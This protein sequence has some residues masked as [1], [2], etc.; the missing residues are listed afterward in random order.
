MKPRR[1]HRA[2][3]FSIRAEPVGFSIA[4]LLPGEGGEFKRGMSAMSPTE[5]TYYAVV[6]SYSLC[7]WFMAPVYPL[8]LAS[9]GLD[10]LEVNLVLVTYLF[11]SPVFEVPT[12]AVADLFGRKRCFILS[13][14]VRGAAFGLY[15]FAQGLTECLVA[16]FIDAVGTTLAS[17]AL[18]AWAVDGML[19]EGAGQPTSRLFARAQVAGRSMMTVAG[20][21]CGYVAD[22]DI[23]MPWV[24]G[25]A[26]SIFTAVLAAVLMQ[27]SPHAVH[28]TK[29]DRPTLRATSLA[30]AR[31]VMASRPLRSLYALSFALACAGFTIGMTWP[32][33][34]KELA[35]TGHWVLG[36]A[37]A[38][39]NLAAVVG[40]LLVQRLPSRLSRGW[41]LSTIA[42]ARGSALFAAALAPG[43]GRALCAL[44]VNETGFALGEPLYSAWINEHVDSGLRATVL[45]VRGMVVMLGGAVGLTVTGWVARDH[46]IPTAWL[47]CA[48]IYWAVAIAPARS[49]RR[50]GGR[51]VAEV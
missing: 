46:G 39:L 1:R 26:G 11:T 32:P 41:F 22:R 35:G 4:P 38:V 45:S 19:A 30:A 25:A 23:G 16:E 18:D 28:P 44:V 12:G 9:R 5:R 34:L 10:L 20:V 43:L 15:Y 49:A 33:R 47:L 31:A 14:L 13:C 21:A 2:T 51:Y 3:S 42:F 37:W 40:A 50:D 36:W 29:R 8:F 17:G 7:A 48:A 24:I 6:S 27:E